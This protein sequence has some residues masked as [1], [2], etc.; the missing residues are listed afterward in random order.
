M[1]QWFCFD[2]GADFLAIETD[3]CHSCKS[4]NVIVTD[5]EEIDADDYEGHFEGDMVSRPP[6]R[7]L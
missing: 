4:R 1:K 7:L 3:T 6:K 5:E 2:C